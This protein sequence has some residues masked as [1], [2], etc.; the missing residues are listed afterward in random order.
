MKI[1]IFK[2]VCLPLFSCLF[3]ETIYFYVPFFH[4]MFFSL[5]HQSV[6]GKGDSTRPIALV[7]VSFFLLFVSLFKDSSPLCYYLTTYCVTV[8]ANFNSTNIYI[9]ILFIIKFHDW[10]PL[11]LVSQVKEIYRRMGL[12]HKLSIA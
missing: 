11:N 6:L 4:L 12:L 3:Q 2:V 9:G 7:S 1:V 5:D 8:C 10:V